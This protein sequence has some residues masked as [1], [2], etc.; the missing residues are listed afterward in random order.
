MRQFIDENP[1]HPLVADAKQ[2]I[3]AL[4]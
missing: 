1:N 2:V 3:E 4:Q